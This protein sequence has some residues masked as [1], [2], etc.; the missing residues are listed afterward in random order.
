[1]LYQQ[2]LTM[3]ISLC[4][5][6]NPP[7]DFNPLTWSMSL[8]FSQSTITYVFSRL[9]TKSSPSSVMKCLLTKPN[10]TESDNLNQHNYFLHK[11]AQV[12]S[13]HDHLCQSTIVYLQCNIPLL[14]WIKYQNIFI[15]LAHTSL[16]C[17]WQF[18][19][20]Q[21]IRALPSRPIRFYSTPSFT[22]FCATSSWLGTLLKDKMPRVH[23]EESLCMDPCPC[24][25]TEGFHWHSK[26]SINA[27]STWSMTI[28]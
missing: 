5:N 22:T 23:V 6:D 2:N 8:G 14:N 15:S 7:I 10:Q 1:M 27:S 18:I 13:D 25:F 17:E 28:Y 24:M 11:T 16:E 19:V 12:I 4:F 21:A 9:V 3:T 26:G 20:F